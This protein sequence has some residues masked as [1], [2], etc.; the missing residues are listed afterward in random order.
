VTTIR[1]NKAAQPL[2]EGQHTVGEIA[3]MV[4]Y[5]DSTSFIRMFQKQ[6]MQTPKKFGQHSGADGSNTIWAE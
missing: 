5:A 3:F 1:L 6:F 4:G 2:L